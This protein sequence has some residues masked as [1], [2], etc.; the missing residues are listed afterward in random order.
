MTPDQVSLVLTQME[1]MLQRTQAV[2]FAVRALIATHPD[3]GAVE[4]VF[5]QLTDQAQA[6]LAVTGHAMPPA[7]REAAESLFAPPVQLDTEPPGA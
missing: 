3:K 2:E 6:R 5:M 4:S 1:R 7:M